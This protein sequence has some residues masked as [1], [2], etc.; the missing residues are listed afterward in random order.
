MQFCQ[1]FPNSNQK[2]EI[3]NPILQQYHA[4]S[5]EQLRPKSAGTMQARSAGKDIAPM[6]RGRSEGQEGA[7]QGN[8]LQSVVPGDLQ[9]KGLVRKE[10][11]LLT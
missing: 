6:H 1:I 8:F 5:V 7:K 9:G 11:F 2:F 10:A 3:V 4:P